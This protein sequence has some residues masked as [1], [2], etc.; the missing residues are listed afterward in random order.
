V[1]SS[2]SSTP[3]R[4]SLALT[5]QFSAL[6]AILSGGVD[7]NAL[8]KPKRSGAHVKKAVP[9]RLSQQHLSTAMDEVIFEELK[10]R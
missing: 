9:L 7:A 5:T 10:A 8:H 6:R 2:F 3:L 4:V 1:T